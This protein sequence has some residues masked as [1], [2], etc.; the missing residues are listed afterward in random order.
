MS[1]IIKNFYKFKFNE[2]NSSVKKNQ[3]WETSFKQDLK[4]NDSL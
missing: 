2:I 4:F 3:G 1:D